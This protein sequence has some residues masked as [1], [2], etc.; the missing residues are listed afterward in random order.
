MRVVIL[1]AVIGVFAALVYAANKKWIKDRTISLLANIA[2]IIGLGLAVIA[3]LPS[4]KRIDPLP[5]IEPEMVLIP[6]GYFIIGSNDTNEF[7]NPLRQD[8]IHV[9]SFYI[10][11]FEISNELYKSFLETN[12][13]HQKPDYWTNTNFKDPNQPVVGISWYDANDYCVWLS[14][15]TGKAYRLPTEAEWEKAARGTNGRTYPWGDEEPNRELANFSS[16]YGKPSAVDSY[17][18]GVND[19]GTANMAGNV[20]EWCGELD[21]EIVVRGG[22]WRDVAIFLKCAS[23]RTNYSRETRKDDIGFRVVLVP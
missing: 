19:Y 8:S 11:K 15:T 9:D 17:D 21:R 22:S 2:T 14:D 16:P 20:A 7:V 4:R 23:R 5:T 18:A 12:A 6:G 10:S 13:A 1:I 3:L